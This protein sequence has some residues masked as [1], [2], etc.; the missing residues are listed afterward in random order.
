MSDWRVRGDGRGSRRRPRFTLIADAFDVGPTKQQC[1]V[2]AGKP[3][4][5]SDCAVDDPTRE[6]ALVDV[7]DSAGLRGPYKGRIQC[8]RNEH[9]TVHRGPQLQHAA[10]F[11]YATLVASEGL[12]CNARCMTTSHAAGK[13][14][15]WGLHDRMRKSAHVAGISVQAMADYFGVSR[16]T[17]GAW[18]N[19]RVEP[20]LSTIRLW[21]LATGVPF[22]WLQTGEMPCPSPSPDGGGTTDPGLNAGR[23]SYYSNAVR[24]LALA[25]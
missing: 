6:R 8:H 22:E 7:E 12:V 18:I 23:S 19:G 3:M 17:V 4:S 1:A 21:A 24:G 11:A 13:I 2:L 25:S 9:C 16:N 10:E 20:S 5:G 15:E 14:P